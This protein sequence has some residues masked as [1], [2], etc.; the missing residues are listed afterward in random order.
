MSNISSKFFKKPVT[1]ISI[2]MAGPEIA[3]AE[4]FL[5]ECES[6]YVSRAM[7]S[8]PPSQAGMFEELGA[9]SGPLDWLAFARDVAMGRASL[10][11]SE[12]G[13]S[14]D[15]QSED[16]TRAVDAL[17]LSFRR[18]GDESHYVPVHP[19]VSQQRVAD[20]L[21]RAFGV[22]V[23]YVR[24][25]RQ[26]G[27]SFYGVYDKGVDV[28]TARRAHRKEP[29]GTARKDALLDTNTPSASRTIFLNVENIHRADKA[30]V[31]VLGH[32]LK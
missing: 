15:D 31:S 9:A 19:T 27:I 25:T 22:R 21:R 24:P 16:D 8:S 12:D 26:G 2:L 17:N 32:E 7:D 6:V 10:D 14:E 29:A 28:D 5:E 4:G 11:T 1:I 20:G 23:V 13:I 30:F 3:D 18:Y